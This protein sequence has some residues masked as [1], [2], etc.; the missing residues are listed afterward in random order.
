MQ[1]YFLNFDMILDNENLPSTCYESKRSKRKSVDYNAS[2]PKK[3]D[4]D[5]DS[6]SDVAYLV[7]ASD[8]DYPTMSKKTK[9]KKKCGP[10]GIAAF[11]AAIAARGASQ[12]SWVIE[13]QE[14]QHENITPIS[15]HAGGRFRRR[16]GYRSRGRIASAISR[17]EMLDT[18]RRI[19]EELRLDEIER[20]SDDT[21]SHISPEILPSLTKGTI[22]NRVNVLFLIS[23]S[24]CFF[25]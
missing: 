12:N 24:N 9:P 10:R 6:E 8:D 23:I 25:R 1:G 18:H 11:R 3:N 15:M 16:S 2:R 13:S 19:A 20:G 21:R 7:D 17:T 14:E 4:N 5:S 22:L